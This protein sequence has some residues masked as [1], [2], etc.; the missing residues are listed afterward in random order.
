MKYSYQ[1]LEKD[2][3]R[4][5]L[6]DLSSMENHV[7]S[8]TNAAEHVVNEILQ[9]YGRLRIQYYDTEGELTELAYDNNGKFTHFI[10]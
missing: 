6:Q 3:S 4:I 5:L 8:I 10:F 2:E 1:V 7:M 9:K